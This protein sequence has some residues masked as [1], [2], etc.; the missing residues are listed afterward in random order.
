EITG[1]ECVAAVFDGVGRDTFEEGMRTLRRRGTMALFGQSSG[2]V[3]KFDPQVLSA[4]GSLTLARPKLADFMATREEYLERA[5]DVF[6]MIEDDNLL[7]RVGKSFR[8]D[9]APE[10]HTLLEA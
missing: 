1:G 9:E 4:K 6:G 2:A 8:L 5:A 3:S 10:A 7:I